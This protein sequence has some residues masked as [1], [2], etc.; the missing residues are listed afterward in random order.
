[1]NAKE[2]TNELLDIVEAAG[3]VDITSENGKDFE[4]NYLDWG[5]DNSIVELNIKE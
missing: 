2:M 1:M 5:S 3:N 4:F